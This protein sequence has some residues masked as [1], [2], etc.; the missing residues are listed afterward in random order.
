[1]ASYSGFK[2]RDNNSTFGFIK[3]YNG[4]FVIGEQSCT[5]SGG[6]SG[7]KLAEFKRVESYFHRIDVN[8]FGPFLR[9]LRIKNRHKS[10]DIIMHER[11]LGC[12]VQELIEKGYIVM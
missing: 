4:L 10:F 2:Y 1:M 8:E 9:S 12:L 6:I 3:N 5:L 11:E 7:K